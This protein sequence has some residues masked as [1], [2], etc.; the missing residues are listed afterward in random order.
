MVSVIIAFYKRLDFLELILLALENQSYTNFE[1]VV[2]ED[3]NDPATLAFLQ[4]CRTTYH[5]SILHVS[6]EDRGFRKNKILNRAIAAATGEK[7][8]F[9]DGDCIPHR[10]FVKNY[11]RHITKHRFFYGRRVMLSETFAQKAL[12]EKNFRPSFV[13]LWSAGCQKLRDALYLPFLAPV[14]KPDRDIWGCNWGVLK[15]DLQSINGFDEDFIT[16]GYGEDID[17]SWRLR[18][19]GLRLFSIRQAVLV[20]HLYHKENYNQQALDSGKALLDE[21]IKAGHWYCKNGLTPS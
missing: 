7:L 4:S 3:D 15:E 2:A 9:I 18:A 1:V 11:A 19:A 20:Y 8:V 21:K 14:Y 6:Q 10:H 16:A 13:Q 17:I 12:K 5:F